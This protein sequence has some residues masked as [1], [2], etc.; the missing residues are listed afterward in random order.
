VVAL[1]QFS[2]LRLVVLAV[3][4]IVVADAMLEAAELIPELT[5]IT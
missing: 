2:E 5:A 3:D 4:E 1:V